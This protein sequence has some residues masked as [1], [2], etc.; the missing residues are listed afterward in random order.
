MPSI[1][2]SRQIIEI[3]AVRESK[4]T[5]TRPQLLTE[6]LPGRLTSRVSIKGAVDHL[7]PGQETEA[8]GRQV[9]ASRTEGAQLPGN[10]GQE[11]KHA[12]DQEGSSLADDALKAE[13][14]SLPA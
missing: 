3:A 14:R 11:I 2:T 4:R 6:P 12:F 1:R 13:H 7:C 5:E 9:R 10:G 8:I